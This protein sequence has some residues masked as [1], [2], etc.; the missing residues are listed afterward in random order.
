MNS[1]GASKA[2]YKVLVAIADELFGKEI[3]EFI[4]NHT[5]PEHTQFHILHS[6]EADLL[7]P[8]HLIPSYEYL[9]DDE[10]CAHDFLK[11]MAKRLRSIVP[12][13][14]VR[15]HL[16]EGDPTQCILNVASK[17][18]AD[19]VIVG[20]HGRTGLQRFLLGSVARSVV[21]HSP[22]STVVIRLNKE[23]A[24]KVSSLLLA[25]RQR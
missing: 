5:W 4:K 2:K 17:L 25:A 22:C 14:R 19:M 7:K 21:T 23:V 6:I 3:L 13:A 1:A 11:S 9:S 10:E 20:S 8:P 12:S 16:M 15:T 24:H 18:K